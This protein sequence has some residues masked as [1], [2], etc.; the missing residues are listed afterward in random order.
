MDT[1][2]LGHVGQEVVADVQ[3]R[4]EAELVK[5]L[6]VDVLHTWLQWPFGLG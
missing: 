5:R 2:H 3:V 1:D 4:G 6:G